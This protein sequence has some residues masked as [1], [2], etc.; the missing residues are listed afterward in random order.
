MRRDRRNSIEAD[1]MKS[2]IKKMSYKETKISQARLINLNADLPVSF[3]QGQRVQ[4]V[5]SDAGFVTYWYGDT[6]T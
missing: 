6:L 1:V 3:G 2:R 4:E 5:G